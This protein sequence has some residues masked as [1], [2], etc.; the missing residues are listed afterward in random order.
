MKEQT[1]SKYNTIKISHLI[2]QLKRIQKEVGDLN[3]VLSKDYEGN[4]YGTLAD[5][6]N[7][8]GL[9]NNMI[10]IYPNDMITE[11]NEINNGEK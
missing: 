5:N 3:I 9:V 11:I 8:F 4:A 2:Y 6:C 10:V 1:M 7:C